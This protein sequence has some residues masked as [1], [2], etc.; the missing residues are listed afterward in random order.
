MN[1]YNSFIMGLIV[2][3]QRFVTEIHYL[4]W[5][6]YRPNYERFYYISHDTHDG[7]AQ[8]VFHCKQCDYD[9]RSDFLFVNDSLIRFAMHKYE[10]TN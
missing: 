7:G 1:T 5:E 4:Y 8:T 2:E 6:R 3:L 10:I 9:I